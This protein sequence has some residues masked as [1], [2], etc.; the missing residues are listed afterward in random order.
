MNKLIELLDKGH[1]VTIG[2]HSDDLTGFFIHVGFAG[3]SEWEGSSHGHI[4]EEAVENAL[5][6]FN[7]E[8]EA[9]YM[10][11]DFELKEPRPELDD[12]SVLSEDFETDSLGTRPDFQGDLQSLI[13]QHSQENLSNTPDWILRDYICNC[14]EAFNCATK[15][16]DDWYGLGA[17]VSCNVPR[18]ES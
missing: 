3:E 13:N 7:H 16:R 5:H 17:A 1:D 12:A 8:L 15:A 10:A 9:L 6:R 4:L 18:G 2:R 14:L 11:D